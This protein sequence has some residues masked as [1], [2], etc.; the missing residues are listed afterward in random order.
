VVLSSLHACW[1]QGRVPLSPSFRRREK[2]VGHQWINVNLELISVFKLATAYRTQG[3]VSVEVFPLSKG[4]ILL[5]FEDSEDG[6]CDD[7]EDQQI[8]KCIPRTIPK[9]APF[10]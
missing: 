10:G 9:G 1:G 5:L 7:S 2:K 6:S 3:D 8:P 4:F